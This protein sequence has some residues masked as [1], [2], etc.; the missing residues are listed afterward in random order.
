MKIIQLVHNPSAGKQNHSRTS[1]MES[2]KREGHLV[3]YVSTEDENWEDFIKNK[4]E[5]IYVAGGD[6]TVHKVASV[7]VETKYTEAPVHIIPLGTANNI[8]LSLPVTFTSHNELFMQRQL[9]ELDYGVTKGINS[10]TYF[11]ESAG[12]GLFPALMKEIKERKKKL[13]PEE[14]LNWILEVLLKMSKDFKPFKA[15]LKFDGVRLKGSFLLIEVM[16][17]Q[18]LGP[19]LNFAPGADASDGYFDLILIPEKRRPQLINYLQK[20]I[21]GE[22]STQDLKSFLKTVKIQNL[23][24]K[25]KASEMHIDDELILKDDVKLKFKILQEPLKFF[26][27]PEE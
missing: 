25:S 17:I 10:D 22:H 24:L 19:N 11:F 21:S 15:K 4:P 9:Q 26:S 3:K 5:V 2:L 12:I 13:S 14:E 20:L 23:S 16:N 27:T 6:G 18:Y 7:L 8:A 1:L